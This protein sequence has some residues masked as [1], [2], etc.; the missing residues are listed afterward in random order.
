MTKE[1][2]SEHARRLWKKVRYHIKVNKLIFYGMAEINDDEDFMEQF[3][4]TSFKLSIMQSVS[5]E[6]IEANMNNSSKWAQCF[7]D[8]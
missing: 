4:Q 5:E 2:K 7:T 6:Q 8:L 1:Q 3:K